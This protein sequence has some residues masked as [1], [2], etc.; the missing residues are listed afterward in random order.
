[1]VRTRFAPSPTGYMHIG[2]LRTALYAYLFAR[3]NNG[4]F[5][6]RIEDTDTERT[7][8]GAIDVIYKTLRQAGIEY[9]EGPDIGGA[10]GPYIQS[11]R[12]D[13]YNYYA[14]KLVE[15]G[16]AYYCFCSKER[17]NRLQESGATKYDKY[18]LHNV[19]LE[20]AKA[21]IAAGE[22]YVVRQ[23]IP[24]NGISSYTDLVFGE[25]TVDYK[26]LE[27]NILLK[28]DGMP[29][30]NFA[31]VVDDHLM[32]ITY[33]IR[34]VEYLTSTNKYNLIY[35]AFGW[36]RPKYI[37]LQPI[38]KDSAHK[39]SK[40]T[41]DAS[42]EDFIAKGY[43][44]QAIVN[45]I[46]LLGWSPKDNREKLS[47]RE[48][49]E[50]FSIEGLS[51]SPSIFDEAKMRWLNSLY[52]KELPQDE[53]SKLS[54]PYYDELGLGGYDYAV[55]D[56]LLRSRIEIMSDIPQKLKFLDQFDNFD[57]SLFENNKLKIDK[58]TAEEVLPKLINRLE[59]IKSFDNA[60]LFE[61]LKQFAAEI[62]LKSAALFWIMRIALTGAEVTPGGAT[63]MAELFGKERTLARIKTAYQR[64]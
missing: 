30:Y 25:I 27:D 8:E 50:A 39:L 53:F 34:G 46:A 48:L 17:L 10:Y 7:I 38:M 4:K 58:A 2:N 57:L 62:N 47:M 60:T 55:L 13:I 6:L 37:H 15:T 28:S 64:L 18:C 23:N 24:Q 45:Y 16:A 1:M 31:N 56:K 35:D 43:L 5:I 29:T 20:E 33:V 32:G 19:S 14:H 42:F 52:L 51:K 36:E 21:R 54:R 9:D 61:N 63:E 40:R 59:G 26:D 41:G 11:Q 49:I 22:P 44:S 3:A 12:K